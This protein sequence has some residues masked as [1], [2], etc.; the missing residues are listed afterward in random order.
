MMNRQVVRALVVVALGGLIL[1]AAGCGGSKSTTTTQGASTTT[2]TS[3]STSTSG[4]TTTTATTTGAAGALGALLSSKNCRDLVNSSA[5]F[6]QAVAG[7]TAS[8]SDLQ[9]SEALMKQFADKTPADI[10]P[11]FEV[12]AA[13][14]AKYAEALKGVDLKSGKVP[15]ADVI[16]RLQKLST[17]IDQAKVAQAS[18][19]IAAWIQKNCTNGG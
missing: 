13:A 3:T 4:T 1:A 8:G 17:E 18:Q 2:T 5:N 16:A 12:L 11:D 6:S 10:R 19:H 7:A 9:K 15:S 14:Y